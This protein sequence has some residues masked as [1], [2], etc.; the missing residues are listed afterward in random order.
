[1]ETALSTEI[2]VNTTGRETRVA[3]LENEQLVELHVNRGS[4]SGYVGNVYLG[5]VVRVLPGMQAAFIDIGLERAAFLYVGDI[6]SPMLNHR[7][8]NEEFN[9]DD[10]DDLD[11]SADLTM[12]EDGPQ[13]EAPRPGQPLIQDLLSE[14]QEI[15][16]QVAKDPIGTK[17]AR[18]TTHIT[19]PGRYL[20]F[21]PT[22]DHVGISRRID[23]D[24]ERRRLRDFVE[25]NRPKGAGFIVR[26]ICQ[27]QTNATLKQD[28]SY[29][30]GIWDKIQEAR[31]NRKAPAPLHTDHGLVLRLVRDAF[32]D[33]VER[34]VVDSPKVF[35][36]ISNFMDDFSSQLKEKL[37]L[38]KGTEPIL[39]AFHVEP[40][41]A[42]SLAR[43]VWLKSGGYLVI[44]QTEAL[45]AIDVNSG[46]YV[47]Q[48]SLED[49][50][51][52]INLEAVKEI[53]YQLRLRNI[54]GII[55]LDLIDMDK[56]QNREKV[57][58]ALD[59]ELKKDRA[60]TN[61]LKISELGLVQMTRKRV[62]E[63]LVRYL[64]EP[65]VYCEGRGNLKSRQTICYEIFREVQR[66]C[67]RVGSKETVFVNAHPTVA[68][69]LYGEEFSTL[70]SIEQRL[71]RRIVVRALQHL[72]PERFEVYGR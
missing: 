18:I 48:T 72:H 10:A 47:G 45:V 67:A 51:L 22:V 7:H 24:K 35:E 5:K 50:T 34:M 23:R 4:D 1:M 33:D 2:I 13:G 55:I 69:M 27:T 9:G 65:C 40:Q 19:L 58:R 30:L 57:Y 20:V 56:E 42:R 6:F 62:Q 38:Y 59:D 31:K 15:V 29:L 52:K 37:H 66:E 26:T 71:S 14:G 70:E 43:K 17:G 8:Q 41:I 21:M 28:M 39:D 36:E 49:T 61:V 11:D 63:D 3:I 32:H 53:V 64:S 68:D 46:R 54:G 16:V 44:D 60:R 12:A 25:K